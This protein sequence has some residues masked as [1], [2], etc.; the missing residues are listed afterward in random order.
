MHFVRLS[1]SCLWVVDVFRA[2]GKCKHH[3]IN[4]KKRK[5]CLFEHR[6]HSVTSTSE[7]YIST[8]PDLSINDW[9]GMVEASVRLLHPV[10]KP[11]STM[12]SLSDLSV[13]HLCNA[14]AFSVKHWIV[15]KTGINVSRHLWSDYSV[16]RV[17][18]PSGLTT[19]CT[20]QMT[21]CVLAITLQLFYTAVF[22]DLSWG[23]PFE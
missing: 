2:G 10:V 11:S 15:I 13:Y 6:G 1:Y 22:Q 8:E 12:E 4:N 23:I 9:L 20:C 7:D 17:T 3:F 14:S 18:L 16:V 21:V 19:L 5:C